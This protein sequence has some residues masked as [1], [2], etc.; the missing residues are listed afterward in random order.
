MT[1][2]RSNNCVL[3]ICI[4]LNNQWSHSEVPSLTSRYSSPEVAKVTILKVKVTL[5]VIEWVKISVFLIFDRYEKC[6][7][8]KVST[9][10]ADSKYVKKCDLDLQ[11]TP[12]RSNNCYSFICIYLNNQW[13]HSELT[14]LTSSDSTLGSAK[15]TILRSRS[16]FRL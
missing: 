3:L 13:S 1:P 6:S 5:P 7:V 10:R 9:W 4:Y 16:H 14:S 11:M 15:V 12:P 2:R 8:L